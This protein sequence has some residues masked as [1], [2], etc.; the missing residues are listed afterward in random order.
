MSDRV[1]LVRVLTASTGTAT[2]TLG[3]A[4]SALFMT[5]AEAGMVNGRT[6]TYL[7]VDGN[8]WELGKGVYTSSGTT[9][10][11]VT[12][13]ASR[14]SGTLGTS[15]ITL[16]GTAQVRIV[17][18]ADDMGALRGT[19]AV[20]GTSDTLL[21]SDLGRA[22]TYSNAASIAVSIAQA[23]SSSSFLDGWTTWI[24]NTGVGTVTITP[25]TSTINGGATLV[26]ATD[27]GALIWSDGTNYHAY[28]L[29]VTKPL[30][31]A[32]SMSNGKI[33]E[34]HAANAVTYAVKTLAGADPS[35]G[36]PVYFR[37]CDQLGTMSAVKAVAALS[38]TIPSG[39]KIGTVNATNSPIYIYAINNASTVV[40]GVSLKYFGSSGNVT[41]V[42]ISGGATSTVMYSTTAQTSKDYLSIGVAYSTQTTAGTWVTTPSSIQLA[43]FPLKKYQF[44][45]YRVGNQSYA[46]ATPT[47]A[48]FNT[49]FMTDVDG[50][51]DMVT[52]FH[53][54]CQEPGV[55]SFAGCLSTNS[56]ASSATYLKKG[57][58]TMAVGT[59]NS[60]LGGAGV[61]ALIELIPGDTV[62][63]QIYSTGADSIYASTGYS[64]FNGGII[65]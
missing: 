58:S 18:S 49:A 37:F 13:L 28:Y 7:I 15:K 31:A 48:Q 14:I 50:V 51:F 52:N 43:P 29:P 21:Q 32:D 8:D 53:F 11:R 19:R 45:V 16:S 60:S 55:Y 22:V 30:L 20:S 54:K 61:T 41:T 42:A 44:S 59:T 36:D 25:A 23:G 62:E 4:Y 38:I 56:G 5:S 12:V 46:A 39:T 47:K 2:M 26:L 40:L 65:R 33:V 64:T 3:A 1:N 27:M 9:L 35:A 24:K 6:Y 10:S 17:E 57:A 34:S 63:L